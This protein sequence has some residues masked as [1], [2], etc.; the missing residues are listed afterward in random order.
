MSASHPSEKIELRAS[1]LPDWLDCPRRAWWRAKNPKRPSSK[2][3][4]A[5]LVGTVAHKILHD[6]IQANGISRAAAKLSAR[7]LLETYIDIQFDQHT[8]TL[9]EAIDQSVNAGLLAFENLSARGLRMRSEL[10][11]RASFKMFDVVVSM[12]EHPD[13]VLYDANDKTVCVVDLKISNAENLNS[14]APQV[15]AYAAALKCENAEILRI[16]R[17][18]GIAISD[19]QTIEIDYAPASVQ[20]THAIKI[21]AANLERTH[22]LEVVANPRSQLCYYCDLY[23]TRDCPETQAHL[24]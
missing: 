5:L 8:Q 16:P 12:S 3:S 24:S 11:L 20:A 18:N 13:A 10:E 22:A 15:W 6:C 23:R 9:A 14:Y 4:I 21:A 1:A 19:V 7:E 2:V 17:R